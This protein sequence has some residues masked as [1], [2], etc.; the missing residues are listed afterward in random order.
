M[1][2]LY[3]ELEQLDKKQIENYIYTYGVPQG[4]Y[5]GNKQWLKYWGESKIKLYKLLG[6]NFRYTFE[7]TNTESMI[8]FLR[9]D[10]TAKINTHLPHLMEDWSRY[11]MQI[12]DILRDKKD[13]YE[14]ITPLSHMSADYSFYHLLRPNSLIANETGSVIKI[15]DKELN[16]TLSF[17]EKCK[18][19]R[20]INKVI[21]FFGASPNIER[22]IKKLRELH[23]EVLGKP[24]EVTTITLSIHP[25]DFITLSHNS[26]WSSCLDWS[27]KGCYS[28]GA[29]EMLNSNNVLCAY[30]SS[31]E[32]L[33]FNQEYKDEEHS[34]PNKIWR[35]LFYITPDIIIGGKAYNYQNKLITKAILKELQQLAFINLRW[36]YQYGIEEYKDT[37]LFI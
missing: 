22:S 36:T 2:N 16:K 8:D 6:N 12:S 33:Y 20:A 15:K 1:F 23:S 13:R 32:P 19:M 35:Q 25:L 21:E 24:H 17:D 18:P 14:L 26:S 10:L 34:C 37:R 9:N 7:V 11:C 27:E 3:S 5:I 29:T 30:I 31:N 4:S 28:L